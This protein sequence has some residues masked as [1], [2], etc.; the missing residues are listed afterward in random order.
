MPFYYVSAS[1]GTNVVKVRIADLLV[2][3]KGFTVI[4]IGRFFEK[5]L[6]LQWLTRTI[7]KTSSIK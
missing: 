4:E 6:E 5:P 7:V 3:T 1:D 2:V